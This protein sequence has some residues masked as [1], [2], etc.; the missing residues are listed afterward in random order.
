M[1]IWLTHK[2]AHNEANEDSELAPELIVWLIDRIGWSFSLRY[3]FYYFPKAN[4]CFTRDD[5]IIN[6][7]DWFWA[8]LAE[9]WYDNN[10]GSELFWIVTMFG[11]SFKDGLNIWFVKI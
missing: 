8:N 2:K 6:Y 7:N 11:C 4:K 3:D 10:F 1:W 9:F 5:Y